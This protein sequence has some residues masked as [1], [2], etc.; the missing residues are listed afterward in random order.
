MAWVML[1]RPRSS[2]YFGRGKFLSFHGFWYQIMSLRIVFSQV[3]SL[4]LIL[5]DFHSGGF[6]VPKQYAKARMYVDANSRTYVESMLRVPVA[7][8][9]ELS[10]VPRATWEAWT[11]SDQCESVVVEAAGS[12]DEGSQQSDT[13]VEA[14]LKRRRYSKRGTALGRQPSTDETLLF[15]FDNSGLLM[16]EL[17]HESGA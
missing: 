7:T 1:V 6:E 4:K 10:L 8:A 2:S 3:F 13:E 5:S 12:D 14:K 11:K 15:P 17:L 16:K 9:K